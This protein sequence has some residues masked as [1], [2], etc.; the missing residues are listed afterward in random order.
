MREI[1]PISDELQRGDI[2]EI[3]Y[4]RPTWDSPTASPVPRWIIA[5]IIDS[6][7]NAWPLARLSDGQL[8]EVRTYMTWRRISGRGLDG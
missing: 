5:E 2:I 7:L 1:R 4:R 6:D 8:T 3:M